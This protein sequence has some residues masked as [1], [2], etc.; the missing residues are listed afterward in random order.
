MGLGLRSPH[1]SFILEN[2]PA[3]GWFEAISENYLGMRTGCDGRPLHILEKIRREYPVVLHGVSLSL[4]SADPLNDEYL[5]RL[6]AL[7][8]RIE[9]A[10]ISDHLCWTGVDGVNLHDLLPLPYTE[11]VLA[12][13]VSRIDRV[14]HYLGR[15]I[16]VENVS[17]YLTFAESGMTEWDFL[18]ELARRADCG[19]LLDV[20]NVYVSAVNHGFDPLEYLDALPAER[21]GQI[22]L[23]GHSRDGDVLID[24]HDHPVCPEVWALYRAA[25]ERFGAVSAMVERDDHIPGFEELYAEVQTAR[26]IQEE[27]LGARD[28]STSQSDRSAA[29]DALGAHP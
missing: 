5:A 29:V 1:Y 17:S 27:V 3:L 24:T 12:Y 23:A 25:V 19:I 16:L 6:K 22:H 20:N 13:L 8:R 14:Q 11:D 21:I 18:S 10:W 26:A 28:G 2:R 9:P 7:A 4:G 15:R